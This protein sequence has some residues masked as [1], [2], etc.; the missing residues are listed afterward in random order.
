MNL[1]VLFS[2][3]YLHAP[4]LPANSQPPLTLKMLIT[5]IVHHSAF[6]L[7]R[8][9]AHLTENLVVDPMKSFNGMLDRSG[10]TRLL[11]NS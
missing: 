8:S 6:S 2:F 3:R 4:A 9:Q 5:I 11:S 1:S 10:N 7:G